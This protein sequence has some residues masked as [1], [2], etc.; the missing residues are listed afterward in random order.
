MASPNAYDSAEASH[1]A[2]RVIRQEL[3]RHPAIEVAQGFPPDAH[4]SVEATLNPAQL[5]TTAGEASLTVRWFAGE[6]PDDPPQFSIHY[7]DDTGFDC[8]WHHEPNPHVEGWGHYQE[9]PDAE[10]AY[11][12]ESYSFGSKI[13]TRV[14]WEILS[15]LATV[16]AERDSGAE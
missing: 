5:K 7:S 3:E 14:V 16:L 9:R 8:G 13:P 10:T 12:Y 6:S 1:R 11:A 2:L 4:A 15:R